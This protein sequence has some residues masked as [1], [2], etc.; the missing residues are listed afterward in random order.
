[1]AWVVAM[2]VTTSSISAICVTPVR[3][4]NLFTANALRKFVFLALAE[5]IEV[6]GWVFRIL[7]SEEWEI[8]TEQCLERTLQI[9]LA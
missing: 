8:A 3:P 7:V 9:S 4:S 2:V 5:L 6:W 1:M